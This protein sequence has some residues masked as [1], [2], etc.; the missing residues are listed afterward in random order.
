MQKHRG[1]KRIWKIAEDND[2]AGFKST[3]GKRAK[4][5][6]GAVAVSLPPY[7]PD[8]MPLE[9]S[10]WKAVEKAATAKIGNKRMTQKKYK[11]IVHKCALSLPKKTVRKAV[12]SMY[13]RIAAIYKN[14]GGHI[15][16]D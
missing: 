6:M 13:E 15:P 12:S 7:S 3:A 16:R 14:K 11:D 10:L 5:N 9:F 8:L 2:P 1:Q 4:K